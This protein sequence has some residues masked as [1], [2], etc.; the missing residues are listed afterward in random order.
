M[1]DRSDRLFSRAEAILAGKS[2]GFGMPILQMLAH[3]RYG[4]AMLSLAARKTDTGKRADLGRFSHATSPAGLMYRAF[5]QGEVNAAQNLALTLFYAG[6]LPGYRKW[7]RRAAR[8][9]DK[10]AAKELSRFEVRQPYPLA[11]RMK[12]IRPFRRDGS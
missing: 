4:P 11:R 2:N 10:D 3:K 5:Q 9:G 1:S 6:D 12:R 8:G 7:L